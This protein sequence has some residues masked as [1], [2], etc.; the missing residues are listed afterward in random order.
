[1]QRRDILVSAVAAG[2][3]LKRYGILVLRFIPGMGVFAPVLLAD[4]SACLAN[5]L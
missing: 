2:I 5:A 4:V 3:D 1:M